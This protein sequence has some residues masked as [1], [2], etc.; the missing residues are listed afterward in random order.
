MAESVQQIVE[1]PREF[2]S[3]GTAFVKRCTKPNKKEYLK[4]IQSVGMGFVIMGAIGYIVKLIHIP[5]R[6]LIT[7]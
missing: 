4:I 7:V 5:I 3:E 2:W 1:Y 6:Q